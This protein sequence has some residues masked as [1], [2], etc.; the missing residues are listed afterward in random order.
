MHADEARPTRATK[1][2]RSRTE[3][4]TASDQELIAGL[5]GRNDFAYLEFLSAVVCW[6]AFSGSRRRGTFHWGTCGGG[7]SLGQQSRT[8]SRIF[9]GA[10]A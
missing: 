5:L 10:F 3:W 4:G 2:I 6:Y 1:Q 7:G 9:R 8:R